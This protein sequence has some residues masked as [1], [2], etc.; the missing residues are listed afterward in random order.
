MRTIEFVG[1]RDNWQSGLLKA[2]HFSVDLIPNEFDVRASL[3]VHERVLR[4]LLQLAT[5][6]YAYELSKRWTDPKK[7][8]SVFIKEGR[9]YRVDLSQ[10]VIRGHEYFWNSG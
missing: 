4:P 3:P 6:C 2:R 9:R 1:G 7:G 10:E 8:G 5:S